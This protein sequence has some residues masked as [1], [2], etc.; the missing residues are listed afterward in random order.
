LGR[1]EVTMRLIPKQSAVM[2]FIIVKV[3]CCYK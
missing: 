2:V 1:R 3:N